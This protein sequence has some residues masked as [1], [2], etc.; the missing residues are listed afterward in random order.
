MSP[1]GYGQIAGRG[2][3]DI[4]AVGGLVCASMKATAWCWLVGSGWLLGAVLPAQPFEHALQAY[5][6]A[7]QRPALYKRTMA[8]VG[9]V[10]TGDPRA[11]EWMRK[12]YDRPEL[13]EEFVRSLAVTLAAGRFT[14]ARYAEAWE[15][16]R[17]KQDDADDVWLWYHAMRVAE[18]AEPGV[19]RSVATS[20]E[21]ASLRVAALDAG[22]RA[23]ATPL[24]S[25]EDLSTLTAVLDSRSARG[26]EQEW[27][28]EAVLEWFAG[29]N[30]SADS[31]TPEQ[32]ALL[33]R[34]ADFLGDRRRTP[35]SRLALSRCFARVLD[36]EDFG[37]DADLWISLLADVSKDERAV[38]IAK[39]R[40]GIT[41]TFFGIPEHGQRICYLI[42]AS[43]SMLEPLTP[44]ER[45]A[46][47][48]LTGQGAKPAKPRDD[49]S[50][51]AE[52]A[53]DWD[54]VESR[55]DAAREL[56]I[57]T[58]QALP[59]DRE[60]CVV[61]FGTDAQC[62]AATP[63]LVKAKDD[64]VDDACAELRMIRPGPQAENRPH[65]TLRGETN[66][67]GAF[68]VAYR[69]TDRKP[70]YEDAHVDAKAFAG[71]CDT[72]FLLSDGAPNWDDFDALDSN[73]G[74]MAGDPET[75]KTYE[76]DGD[77]LWYGPFIHPQ[78]LLPDLARYQLLRRCSIHAV[79]LGEADYGFL[80]RVA[81]LGHGRT[82]KI[83]VA[84]N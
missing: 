5:K 27:L 12:D 37:P 2:A 8:R 51:R 68:L 24:P 53:I 17:S 39:A 57:L 47:M 50:D 18:L 11:L 3:G 6:A 9:L 67:H 22:R 25:G 80:E 54:R 32:R 59:E 28:Y 60:F 30:A 61:L 31:L 40:A 46:L 55:F 70:V 52:R 64:A 81:N 44:R 56:L 23:S 66:L 74:R 48:P 78:Y 29:Q 38:R 62:L 15:D 26:V 45:E 84:G 43:D 21:P 35:R 10:N 71:G 34:I 7:M 79:G 14:D 69:T 1:E 19:W 33:L 36:C 4:G 65:G 41:H 49:A 82:L 63:R 75:G 72:I 58:L 77:L 76:Y 20:R 13:P 16:W 73:D 83:G 42:D